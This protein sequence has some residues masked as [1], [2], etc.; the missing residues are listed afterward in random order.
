MVPRGDLGRALSVS[1]RPASDSTDAGALLEGNTLGCNESF[2]AELYSP[3]LAEEETDAIPDLLS[4]ASSRSD[5]AWKS[6]PLPEVGRDPD[7]PSARRSL[8][9]TDDPN[10]LDPGRDPDPDPLDHETGGKSAV[11]AGASKPAVTAAA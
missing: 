11:A 8:L 4:G 5:I 3:S 7:P 6:A 10:D 2:T 1:I 9:S